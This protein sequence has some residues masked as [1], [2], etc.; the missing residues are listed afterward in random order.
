M[1]KSF[2]LFSSLFVFGCALLLCLGTPSSASAATYFCP[3]PKY[4]C[5]GRY[6]F[7][8]AEL[9]SLNTCYREI[10]VI[11]GWACNNGVVGLEVIMNGQYYHSVTMPNGDIYIWQ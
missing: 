7:S 9:N 2:S 8:Q 4:D 6:Y 3:P 11:S 1:N 5:Q 10:K